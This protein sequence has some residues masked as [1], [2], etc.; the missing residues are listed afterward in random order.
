MVRMHPQIPK[1]ILMKAPFWQQEPLA[2]RP[3]DR[4][5]KLGTTP[6][7]QWPCDWRSCSCVSDEGLGFIGFKG[8]TR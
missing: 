2:G 3:D 8:D 1:L 4:F 6:Q 5:G 7:R